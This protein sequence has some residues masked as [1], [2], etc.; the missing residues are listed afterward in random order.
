MNLWHRSL[1][2]MEIYTRLHSRCNIRS[3]GNY[4][5][6]EMVAVGGRNQKVF[7]RCPK[8]NHMKGTKKLEKCSSEKGERQPSP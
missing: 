7:K 8:I 2:F 1:L 6:V 5:Q 4:G 3:S